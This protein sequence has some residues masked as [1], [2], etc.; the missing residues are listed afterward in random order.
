MLN[1]ALANLRQYTIFGSGAA[2]AVDAK[3]QLQTLNGNP[4]CYLSFSDEKSGGWLG[5]VAFAYSRICQVPT[6]EIRQKLII[7]F[8]GWGKAVAF[9]V[10]NGEPFGSPTLTTTPPIAL[11]LIAMDV[12]MIWNKPR[13]PQQNAVVEKKQCTSSRWAEVEKATDL[14]DLQKR[15]D[16][17]AVLQQEKLPVKRLQAKTRLEAFPELETSRRIYH[18]TDFDPQKVYN[19]FGGSILVQKSLYSKSVFQWRYWTLRASIFG[20]TKVQRAVC[21]NKI[22]RNPSKLARI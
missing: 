14:Q 1:Q 12:D 6:E 18:Y 22:R 4:A 15:L 2:R 7:M 21:T 16:R 3:E 17:E 8:L 5:S 20:R 13:T 19:R 10:D 9:R 11:W